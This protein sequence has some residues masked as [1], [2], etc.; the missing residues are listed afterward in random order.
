MI[1]KEVSA[2]LFPWD[3]V[4]ESPDDI[5]DN[6]ERDTLTNS[7]YPVILMHDEK[8]PLSEFYYPH[9]PR[10][11]VYWTED[12]RANWHFDPAFYEESRIKPL[13]SEDKELAGTDWVQFSID[14]ARRRGMNIG[15][16]LS[17]TWVDKKRL[18]DEFTEC[19]QQNIDGEPI[20]VQLCANNPDT[21]AYARA[22]YTE[23]ATRYELDFIQTCFYGF[24]GGLSPLLKISEVERLLNLPLGGCFCPHCEKEAE[25][26]GINF[27]E[28]KDRLGWIVDGH[29]H[30]NHKQA[31]EL[32]LLRHSTTTAAQ[33]FVEMPEL[34]QWFKFRCDSFVSFWKDIYTAAHAARPAIDVR[35]NDCFVYP[36]MIGFNLR[37]MSPYF[38]SIRGADYF[39]QNG[40]PEL[41]E[42]KRGFYHSIRRAV[43]LDKHFVTALSQRMKA[44]PELIKETIRIS[45]ECG[46]DGTTIANY[47][48]ATPALMKAVRE[49]FD[50]VGIEVR[51]D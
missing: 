31:F 21:R 43:G 32:N 4:D 46:A 16:E 38:D 23:L 7:F 14:L 48:T 6:L 28:V 27:S 3:F 13:R 36:E 20:G 35:F 39:E 2:R 22:L 11:K 29:K 17:H 12:S 26:R 44:T 25:K 37:E 15:V 41:M 1:F 9:N 10:R 33:L 34:Y 18:K 5:L 40:D 45:A 47:D 49:G 19:L 50:E 42:V 8:R 51:R 24:A 30:Y